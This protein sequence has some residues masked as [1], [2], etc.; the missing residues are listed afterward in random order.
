MTSHWTAT[1]HRNGGKWQLVALHISA[2]LFDNPVIAAARRYAYT[3]T[4]IA[5]IAGFVLGFALRALTK[6]S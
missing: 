3:S 5:A 1:V 4:A 6:R 2:G